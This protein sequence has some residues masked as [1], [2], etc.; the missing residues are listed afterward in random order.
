MSYNI[1][2]EPEGVYWKYTGKVSGEE[3]IKSTS[4]IYGD[5]RFDDISYKFVDFEDVESIDIKEHEVS[6]IA[7]QHKAAALSNNTIKTA[8]LIKPEL[9]SLADMFVSFFE[10]SDWV[11]KVFHEYEDVQK[12]L[13]RDAGG[14]QA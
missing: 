13:E 1:R 9:K 2:W 11:V 10:D 14:T 6:L 4:T 7:F 5:P 3:I 12:W 8:I